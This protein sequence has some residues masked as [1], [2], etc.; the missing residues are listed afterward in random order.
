M[1]RVGIE[2]SVRKISENLGVNEAVQRKMFR[3]WGTILRIL[4]RRL[5]GSAMRDFSFVSFGFL[6]DLVLPE[7]TQ[8]RWISQSFS[9]LITV[10]AW[11][12]NAFLSSL[13]SLDLAVSLSERLYIHRQFRASK[14][15]FLDIQWRRELRWRI[16]R[17]ISRLFRRVSSLHRH[18]WGWLWFFSCWQPIH[19][20][21]RR[22]SL[23]CWK[24]F[25]DSSAKAHSIQS[26]DIETTESFSI[27]ARSRRSSFKLDSRTY[28]WTEGSL[29]LQPYSWLAKQ[30]WHR[31]GEVHSMYVNS[32]SC[33]RNIF[34]Y[35][36]S[37]FKGF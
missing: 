20:R 13:S 7:L 23:E 10:F 4:L 29:L 27:S 5:L 14:A 26:S 6:I 1:H 24:A 34:I 33:L 17:W 30:Q 28:L 12:E 3:C 37:D 9:S 32:A 2:T 21:R 8:S 22:N 25:R 15:R 35:R 36:R 11:F 16:G 18:L 19:T 31:E